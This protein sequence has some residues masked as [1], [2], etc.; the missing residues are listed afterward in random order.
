MFCREIREKERER[1]FAQKM[2]QN[3]QFSFCFFFLVLGGLGLFIM[4]CD[5]SAFGGA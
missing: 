4:V 2:L 1:E 3:A 5:L